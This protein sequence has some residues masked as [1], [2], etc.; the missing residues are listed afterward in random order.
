MGN[1]MQHLK[2]APEALKIKESGSGNLLSDI[3]DLPAAK[4]LRHGLCFHCLEA[5]QH[6]AVGGLLHLTNAYDLR[7]A[8]T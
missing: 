4:L 5:L 7:T 3:A 8:G 6:R 2:K 1:R